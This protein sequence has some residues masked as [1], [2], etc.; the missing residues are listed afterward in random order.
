MSYNGCLDDKITNRLS[1]ASV[2]V[3]RLEQCLRKS[4]DI[5]TINKK[6]CLQSCR[7]IFS[8]VWLRSMDSIQKACV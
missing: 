8:D 5:E 1:K 3:G 2:A 7:I 4:H 6:Q